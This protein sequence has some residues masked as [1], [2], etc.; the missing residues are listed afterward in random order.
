MHCAYGSGTWGGGG[1]EYGINQDATHVLVL[2]KPGDVVGNIFGIEAEH[3][4]HRFPVVTEQVDEK[5]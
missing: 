3:H 1:A 4:V 2:L 5:I